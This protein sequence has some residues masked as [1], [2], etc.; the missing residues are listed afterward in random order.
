MTLNGEMALISRVGSTPGRN[1]FILAQRHIIIII[2]ITKSL[3]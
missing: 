3:F 2:I 1:K